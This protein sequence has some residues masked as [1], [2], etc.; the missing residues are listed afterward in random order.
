MRS[1]LVRLMEEYPLLR[2]QD[3]IGYPHVVAA[4]LE[5]V[6]NLAVELLEGH[7]K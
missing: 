5:V 1:V 4:T 2:G 3:R 6:L 7:L